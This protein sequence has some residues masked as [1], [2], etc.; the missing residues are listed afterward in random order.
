MLLADEEIKLDDLSSLRRG[1]A[2]EKTIG[3][4][5][6]GNKSK[7]INEVTKTLIAIDAAGKE[8]TQTEIAQIHGTKQPVVSRI[9]KEQ[10]ENP[11]VLDVVSK[12][13]EIANLANNKLLETLTIFDPKGLENQME[14]VTAFSKLA[15]AVEK[16][17]GRA[18]AGKE[19]S[20]VN[21]V[22]F[23]PRDISVEDYKKKHGTIIV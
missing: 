6:L 18:N 8:L 10:R 5:Q 7:S 21:I 12:T 9:A 1:N 3:S 11:E 14:V 17:N 19:G 22:F 20:N 4:G 2:V 13:K 23:N 16:V 15:G